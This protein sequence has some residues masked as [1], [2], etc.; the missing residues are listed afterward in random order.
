MLP[1]GT[2]GRGQTLS[3]VSR[4]HPR[5]KKMRSEIL[6]RT[7]EYDDMSLDRCAVSVVPNVSLFEYE[8]E[9]RLG[10]A[11]EIRL[12]RQARTRQ[13]VTFKAGTPAGPR[14]DLL[15]AA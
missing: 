12:P 1:H 13:I 7:V 2:S 3:A 15:V 10:P 14:L 11:P 5:S 4:R 9:F 6:K 8:V